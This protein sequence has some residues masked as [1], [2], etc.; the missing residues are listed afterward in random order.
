MARLHRVAI[1]PLALPA[2]SPEETAAA[3]THPHRRKRLLQLAMVMTT[4]DG[5][6]GRAPVRRKAALALARGAAC[7]VDLSDHWDFWPHLARPLDE[8]RAELTIPPPV[9]T[10]SPA[11][12]PP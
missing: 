11:P 2:P 5:S 3:I 8:V 10:S 12:S 4:I 6:V 9:P 7:A 1:D